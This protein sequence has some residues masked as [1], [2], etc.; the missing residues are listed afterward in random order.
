MSLDQIKDRAIQIMRSDPDFWRDDEAIIGW[1]SEPRKAE[2][3]F[4]ERI[5]A[6]RNASSLDEIIDVL[7]I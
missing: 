3:V 7:H 1:K 5:E 2:D 4:E 6:V